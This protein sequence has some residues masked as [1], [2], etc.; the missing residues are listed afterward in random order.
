MF[1][2]LATTIFLVNS[3]NRLNIQTEDDAYFWIHQLFFLESTSVDI[4]VEEERLQFIRYEQFESL[5][6]VHIFVLVP[7]FI[8]DLMGEITVQVLCYSNENL[9]ESGATEQLLGVTFN[10]STTMVS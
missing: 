6:K 8:F 9:N 2:L 7:F 3:L 1:I 4:F 5:P 10:Q